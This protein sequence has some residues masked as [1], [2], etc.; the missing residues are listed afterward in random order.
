MLL[1]PTAVALAGITYDSVRATQRFYLGTTSNTRLS[2]DGSAQTLS[3]TLTPASTVRYITTWTL[4]PTRATGSSPF[5]ISAT[6]TTNALASGSMQA[7]DVVANAGSN[8]SGGTIRGAQIKARQPDANTGGLT[9]VYISTDIKAKTTTNARGLE[10]SLDGLAG[11]VATTSQG[12]V[13]Y[14]NS[15]GNQGTSIA[16][17]VNGGTPTGHGTFTYDVR[18]QNGAT[19]DEAADGVLNLDNAYL[20]IQ[21]TLTSQ[22]TENNNQ[23]VDLTT[24]STYLNGTNIT[25][26]GGYGSSAIDVTGTYSG[27]NGGYS[28]VLSRITTSGA[29]TADGAGVV[30]IKSVVTNTANLTDGNIYG[31]QFIAKHSH[32]TNDM[33]A[34]ASLI[35]VEGWAY[36]ANVGHVQ[37]MIGGNFGYHIEATTENHTAGSVARGLQVFCD[38]ASSNTDPFEETALELWN[39]AGDQDN[40]IQITHSGSGFTYFLSTQSVDGCFSADT[41]SPAGTTTHKIKVNMNGTTGYIPVYADY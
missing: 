20:D 35:G 12:V 21:R 5:Y 4:N 25:Y 11:G 19:L 30:G 13:V 38:D 37:T 31:G 16:Y 29:H 18:F 27:V 41:G 17:D 33:A 9:G 8:A 23:V 1:L 28:G 39:M 6:Q 24:D 34:Q 15:S 36:P 40:A 32:A 22:S 2:L 10:V 14:H 26:S 7:L 3:L